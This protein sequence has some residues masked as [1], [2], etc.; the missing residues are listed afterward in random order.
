MCPDDAHSGHASNLQPMADPY[1]AGELAALRERKAHEPG[2]AWVDFSKEIVAQVL[3]VPV[4]ADVIGADFDSERGIVRLLFRAPGL[5]G[6][7][8]ADAPTV[9]PTLTKEY[10][11]WE[12]NVR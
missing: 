8:E 6:G 5:P 9:T 3:H 7:T 1:K 12:W 11:R 10:V 2:Y 4:D